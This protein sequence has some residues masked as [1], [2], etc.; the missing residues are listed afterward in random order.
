MDMMHG[1]KAK[2]GQRQNFAPCDCFKR[3]RIEM[4]SRIERHPALPH[5]MA[6]MD[7]GDRQSTPLRLSQQKILNQFFLDTIVTERKFGRMFWRG[8]Q[9][10]IAMCPDR[11]NMNEMRDL[12][13]QCGNKLASAVYSEAYEVNDS[14]SLKCGQG[15]AKLPGCQWRR[16]IVPDGGVKVYRSG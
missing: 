8:N 15:R 10:G 9:G 16:Q 11:A 1:F 6:G 2:I 14:V 12:A 5:N 3:R 4:T 13:M 7:Q